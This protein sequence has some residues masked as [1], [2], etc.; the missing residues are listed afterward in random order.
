MSNSLY[1]SSTLLQWTPLQI[2]LV[3]LDINCQLNETQSG[4]TAQG[5][6]SQ[7]GDAL[8]VHFSK[9]LYA[10][11][12][13]I[14]YNYVK[15][16]FWCYDLELT[17]YSTILSITTSMLSISIIHVHNSDVTDCFKLCGNTMTIKDLY[18]FCTVCKWHNMMNW[19]SC[20][21]LDVMIA[22]T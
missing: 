21:S 2:Q 18:H 20:G 8:N 10:L 4:S 9:A 11:Q 16:L 13:F 1:R 22:I 7:H 6:F 15:V 12:F 3:C 19:S 17:I 5:V 14:N